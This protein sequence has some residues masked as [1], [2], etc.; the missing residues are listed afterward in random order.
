MLVHFPV[1]LL[2]VALSA[3]AITVAKDQSLFERSCTAQ[4]GFWLTMLTTVSAITAAIF[5]DLALDIACG[6]G[7]TNRFMGD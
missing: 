4:T 6:A 3:Q 1:A 7:T 5:G 2:P